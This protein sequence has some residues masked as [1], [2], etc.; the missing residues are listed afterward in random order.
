[1]RK[2]KTENY[3]VGFDDSQEIKDRVFDALIEF[4]CKHEAF[5]GEVIMQSDDPQI[6]ATELLAEIADDIINFEY[7]CLED[8]E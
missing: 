7:D 3:E 4:Y 2:V 1:M 8:D 5:S 6:Y